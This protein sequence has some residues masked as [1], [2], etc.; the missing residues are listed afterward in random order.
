MIELR[1][2]KLFGVIALAIAYAIPANGQAGPLN[3]FELASE[4]RAAAR[5]LS[6]NGEYEAALKTLN[7][8]DAGKY[9]VGDAEMQAAAAKVQGVVTDKG[10]ILI[11]LK[12]YEEAD[13]EFYRAFDV[14]VEQAA[15]DLDF[16]RTNGT[17]GTP[18]SGTKASDALVSAAGSVSR[19]KAIIELRDANYLLSGVSNSTRPFDAVRLAKYE[20]LRKGVARFRPSN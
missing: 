10:R 1:F 12:R 11:K 15:K 17:G 14:S 9:P 8:L 18:E 2:T 16:V 19:A 13:A 7:S 20:S 3:Q 6:D 5:S 4:V